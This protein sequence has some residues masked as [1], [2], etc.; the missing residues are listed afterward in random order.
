MSH[1]MQRRARRSALILLPGL[2]GLLAVGATVTAA[3]GPQAAAD[4]AE[5]RAASD[6]ASQDQDADAS[7]AHDSSLS[8]RSFA[9]EVADAAVS[10]DAAADDWLPPSFEAEYRVRFDGIPFTVSGTRSLKRN[11]D[12]SLAFRSRIHTWLVKI[13]ESARMHLSG[14]G[15]LQPLDYAFRQRGIAGRKTRLLDF[16]W[17]AGQVER[18]GDKERT[19]PLDQPLFDPASWQLAL[20]RDLARDRAGPGDVLH[21]PIT[22]GGDPKVYEI[23]VRETEQIEL[24]AGEFETVLLE[25]IFEPGEDRVTR[26]WLAPAHD[27]LLVRLE[28]TDDDGRTLRLAMSELK[29]PAEGEQAELSASR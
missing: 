15:E 16:D 29:L 18:S 2:V 7:R 13:D 21:Y 10:A 3:H 22:D 25:R 12:D 8:Q 24:P 17:E 28:L 1:A 26:I 14:N 11:A 4:D 23:A 6:E 27:W 5:I 9:T 20:R 19:R